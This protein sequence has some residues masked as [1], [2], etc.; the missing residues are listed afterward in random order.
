VRPWLRRLLLLLAAFACYVGIV[1]VRQGPPPGGDTTPLTAVT[2]ALAAGRLH[3]AAAN[4]ELPNPPGYALMTAPLVA[5]FRSA[6][7]SPTWCTTS[8]R[9]SDLRRLSAYRHDPT[10]AEDVAECGSLH[11]L[12]NGEVRPSLPS[13]YRAQGILGLAGWLVLALGSLALLW[14]AGAAS[15]AREAALLAFLAFLPAASSAIVQL[16]HPQDIVSLGLALGAMALV[17]RRRWI[18]AGAFFGLA[19]LT[20][21]YA[22]LL[23]IPALAA[24]PGTGPR[25]RVGLSAAV[26]FGVG[27]APFF[28]SAPHATIANFSGFSAGG[29]VSGFTVLSLSGV[30]G[31]AA[32]AIARDAPVVFA[33]AVC[34]WAVRRRTW[35]D[36]PVVLVALGL[37]CVGGRL[38]FESVVFPYYLLASSVLFFLL[39]LVA[40]RTPHRSLAWCAAAAFFVAISPGN[41]AVDALGTLILA[42]LA[43]AAGLADVA[44]LTDSHAPKTLSVEISSDAV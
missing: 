14:A 18:V 6:V 33:L 37:A 31:S 11:R 42:V 35:T 43:V 24:A 22:L 38:V 26:V 40:Q 19:V 20:K 39:D 25:L 3:A 23:L 16:Y 9:A 4:D 29:A 34:I 27:L 17:L 32:S 15:A 2:S 8:G 41:R 28:L 10:F 12:A 7:G 44:R 5:L 13:W 30:T 21:Q 1:I 36:I